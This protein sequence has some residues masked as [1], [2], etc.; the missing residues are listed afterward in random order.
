LA[1]SH[2]AG[3][4]ILPTKNPNFERIIPRFTKDPIE[5]MDAS[6]QTMPGEEQQH[7]EVERLRDATAQDDLEMSSPQ[8]TER[9]LS[10]ADSVSTRPPTK[11]RQVGMAQITIKMLSLLGTAESSELGSDSEFQSESDGWDA[12]ECWDDG[13]SG[14]SGKPGADGSGAIT[15]T[16]N[17]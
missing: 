12:G 6:T 10:D 16:T 15:A 2:S 9:A 17:S 3:K 8:L 5:T 11:M 7:P 13:G 1:T 14:G 4:A